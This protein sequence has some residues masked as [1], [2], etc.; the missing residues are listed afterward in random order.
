[1]SYIF[2]QLLLISRVIVGGIF[3]AHGYQKLIL[4]GLPATAHSFAQVGVPSPSLSADYAAIVELFGGMALMLGL[5]LPLVGLL[6]GADMLGA[7][8]FVHARHGLIVE[9][10]GFEYVVTLGLAALLLGFSDGGPLAFDSLLRSL[11]GRKEKLPEPEIR[12]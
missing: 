8:L 3:M 5:A 9:Q 4:I 6:L 2:R 12:G 11:F 10:G 1:M 7:F